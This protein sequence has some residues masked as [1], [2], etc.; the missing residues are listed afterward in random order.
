MG[1]KEWEGRGGEECSMDF[2]NKKVGGFIGGE[3]RS[4]CLGPLVP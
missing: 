2:V 4:R 3:A 1:R